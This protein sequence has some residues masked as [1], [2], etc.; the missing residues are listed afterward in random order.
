MDHRFETPRGTVSWDVDSNGLQ[1]GVQRRIKRIPW[2]EITAAGLIRF[3]DP[4]VPS[5]FPTG[6]LP[7]LGKLMDLD[8]R[9]AHD[10]RQLTLARGRST[11]RAMRVPIPVGDPEAAALVQAVQAKLGD[12][13]VGEVSIQDQQAALGLSTPW[14]FYLLF[15]FGFVAFGLTILFAIGAFASLTSGQWAGV[16]P[17][18]WLAL[19]FWL[20][21]VGG[22]LFLYRRRA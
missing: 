9:L 18:A 21:L 16:P 20:L 12:R 19:L 8:R 13:W 15:G 17:V 3:S 22:I 4:D 2:Q 10:L 14:W 5:D 6:I 1:L 7:G 11:F